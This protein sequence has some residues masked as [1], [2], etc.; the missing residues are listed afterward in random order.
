M[1]V[2]ISLMLAAVALLPSCATVRSSRPTSDR[3]RRHD[4]A[5]LRR[6]A[7]QLW[8]A[9][10]AEDWATVFQFQDPKLRQGFDEAQF[11]AWSEKEEPFEIHSF[12]IESAVTDG[13]L[14]WVRVPY[15]TSMRRFKGLE[16]RDAYHLQKWRRIDGQ[17]YPIPN[18][19]ADEYPESPSQRDAA[20]ERELA[21]RFAK[22]W[23]ARRTADWAELYRLSDPRDHER[24]LSEEFAAVEGLIEYFDHKVYWVQ[25]IGDVGKIRVMYY[26]KVNDPSMQNLTPQEKVK[27]ERWVKFENEWYRDLIQEP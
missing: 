8:N 20:A 13:D 11:A 6:R 14:G 19:E 22:S 25:V 18:N 2:Y 4:E 26:H 16:P 24:V 15:R 5:A 1:R 23:E 7:E 21:A 12:Q 27:V 3:A 17:W 9:K 10:V